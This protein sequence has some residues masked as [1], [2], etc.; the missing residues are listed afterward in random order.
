VKELGALNGSGRTPEQSE[1]GLFYGQI[2][3][4]VQIGRNLVKLA[5]QQQLG[6]TS[7]GQ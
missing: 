6:P 4:A 3:A 7:G 1:I 5:E 2:N